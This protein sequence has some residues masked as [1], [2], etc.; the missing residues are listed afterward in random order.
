MSRTLVIIAAVVFLMQGTL[1][2]LMPLVAPLSREIGMPEW[3]IGLIASAGALCIVIAGPAWGRVSQRVGPKPVL[4]AAVGSG[5]LAM[6]AFAGSTHAGV[7]GVVGAGVAAVLM[8]ATRGFWY[9][10]TEAAILPT[11]QAFVASITP[12]PA[13]RV[14]GMAVI[15]AASGASMVVG[16]A[17]G[18]LAGGVSLLGMMWA[19]PIA[20]LAILV[21]VVLV[22]PRRP[23][24]ERAPEPRRLR[25][26]DPRVWP[27]LLVSFLLY[28]ALGFL[29][30]LIGFIAQDRLGL[31]AGETALVAGGALMC[32]GIGLVLAQAVLV[33][34]L[35]WAPARFVLV[36][37][38]VATIG[39]GLLVIDGGLASILAGMLVAGIGMGL[40]TPGVNSGASLSVTPDEQGSVAGLIA[41]V[42]ALTMI[43]SPLAATFLYGVFP[44]APSIVTASLAAIVVVFVACHPAFRLRG[45]LRRAQGADAGG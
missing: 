45:S 18:G 32:A 23:P 26:V 1:V 3:Q 40:A 30:I 9:G 39:F 37:S 20:L 14:K 24:G 28:T 22:L 33:R 13:D 36:G 19:V 16:P 29:D 41:S 21:F 31:S 15:G 35:P 25:F 4:I 38:A 7:A 43:V 34:L 2:A 44:P 17:V 42:N 11:A 8:L 27:Y 6:A 10:L 12:D 5:V